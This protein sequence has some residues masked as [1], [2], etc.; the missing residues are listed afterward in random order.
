MANEKKQLKLSPDSFT[1]NDKGEV[2]I[3][4]SELAKVIKE[5]TENGT[6]GEHGIYIAVGW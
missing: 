1:V 4:N 6:V 5:N 3:N 2:M